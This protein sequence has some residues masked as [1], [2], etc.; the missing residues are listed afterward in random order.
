MPYYFE[1]ASHISKIILPSTV[2]LDEV[3]WEAR[4]VL[5]LQ[6]SERIRMEAV[7]LEVCRVTP[8]S[9]VLCSELGF[10]K[11]NMC[12]V[13]GWGI[14]TGSLGP[15]TLLWTFSRT[16][17][18]SPG[19]TYCSPIVFKPSTSHSRPL[20][21][22]KHSLLPHSSLLQPFCPVT[23]YKHALRCLWVCVC[24]CVL[25]TCCM[26]VGGPHCPRSWGYRNEWSKSFVPR[27][28]WRGGGGGG[29]QWKTIKHKLVSE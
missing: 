1:P 18:V 26:L 22:A 24:A 21:L 20:A 25:G 12:L 4:F 2:P 23:V 8:P 6:G 27:S 15:G 3:Q 16:F 9:E 28:L 14:V 5:Q 13:G 11:H 29:V 17:T 19:A 10:S 7:V